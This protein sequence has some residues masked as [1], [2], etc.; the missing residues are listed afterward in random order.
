[1]KCDFPYC[2]REANNGNYCYDHYRLMGS[3]KAKE[4]KSGLK[5]VSDKRKAEDKE[6]SK[7]KREYLKANPFC[8]LKFKGCTKVATEIHHKKSGKDRAANYTNADCF[9][10]VCAHCHRFGHDKLS[11]EEAKEIGFKM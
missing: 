7:L 2:S 8:E 1:M 9:M 10:S 3:T 5:K 11:A 4:T 6:Y